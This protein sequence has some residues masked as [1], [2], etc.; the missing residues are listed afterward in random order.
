MLGQGGY[1]VLDKTFHQPTNRK[2]WTI[3]SVDERL[4]EVEAHVA[5]D[6]VRLV[7]HGRIHVGLCRGI[8][9]LLRAVH[10]ECAA[11]ILVQY[12]I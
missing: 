1:P 7:L 11:D 6:S 4:S 8:N 10:G 12:R 5:F 2:D 9:I 3:S